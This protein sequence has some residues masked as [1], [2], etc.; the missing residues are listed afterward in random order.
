MLLVVT[1]CLLLAVIVVMAAYALYRAVTHRWHE[2]KVWVDG[3]S[4][5]PV[6]ME[7]GILVLAVGTLALFFLY[8]A[9]F[10]TFEGMRASVKKWDARDYRDLTGKEFSVRWCPD[11]PSG[12]PR[13]NAGPVPVSDGCCTPNSE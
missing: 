5:A 12:G 13:R 6:W 1:T 10:A 11:P 9:L 4:A 2:I 7:I 8:F 3:L